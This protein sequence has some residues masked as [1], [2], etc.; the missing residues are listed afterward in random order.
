NRASCISC[1][2]ITSNPLQR[3]LSLPRRTTRLNS[4]RS[5]PRK[6]YGLHN[7]ILRRA[8][9]SAS[10]SSII[11]RGCKGMKIYPAIDILGGK[12]VRLRQGRK[13]DV[14]VYGDPLEMASKWVRKGAEWLHVV[15]LDGAFDGSPKNLQ[16]LQEMAIALP[17]AKIQVGGGI[18]G[19]AI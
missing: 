18:R 9:T 11:L 12:A 7:F 19:K 13:N 16:I 6:T 14:T 17:S 1:T 15:D 5:S 2:R 8:S 10:V 4:P 3:R